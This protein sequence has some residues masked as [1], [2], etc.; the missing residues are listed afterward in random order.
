MNRTLLLAAYHYPPENAIGAAR[1]ARF[2]KYLPA[3]GWDC[4]VLTAATPSDAARNVQFVE[5]RTRGIWGGG[6]PANGTA[7]ALRKYTELVLRR[8]FFPGTPGLTWWPAVIR[9]GVRLSREDGCAPAAVLST[10]PPLPVHLAGR[11]LARKLGIPWIADFRDPFAHHLI[12]GMNPL[13]ARAY[14]RLEAWVFK[15]AAAVILNTEAAAAMYRELYPAHA[16]KM[17]VIWNGYD[18]DEDLGPLPTPPHP[19]RVLAHVGTF[20]LGRNPVAIL[21]SLERLRAAGDA[22]ALGIEVH[23]T[24]VNF[25]SPDE[26]AVIERCAASGWVRANGIQVPQAEARRLIREADGLLLI[27]PQSGIQVPGKTFEYIQTGRPILSL[28]PKKSAVEWMLE[29]SGSRYT[30]LYP[31]DL[32]EETDR[33]LAE[34]LRGDW[35][36]ST[37]SD[38]FESQFNAARQAEQLA[39]ILNRVV[40]GQAAGERRVLNRAGR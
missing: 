26:Q 35:E 25:S 2:V 11:R 6:L 9:A 15:E 31:D 37:P 1:P 20:Y 13:S 32:P 4:Q 8:V 28:A 39:G 16:G 29:R 7:S 38:W 19:K 40:A 17:H 23:L 3:E 14:R 24:G 21:E 34:F 30:N 10:F 36:P 18:P 5:D 12:K 33:K 27:Q 22:A